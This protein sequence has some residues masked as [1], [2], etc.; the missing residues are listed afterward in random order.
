MKSVNTV[1]F[2]LSAVVFPRLLRKTKLYFFSRSLQKCTFCVICSQF[3]AKTLHFSAVMKNTLPEFQNFIVFSAG[4]GHQKIF[5]KP[6]IKKKSTVRWKGAHIPFDTRTCNRCEIC[7]T[8]FA[9][10]VEPRYTKNRE[11]LYYRKI[12]N[13]SP[14]FD[15]EF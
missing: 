5:I 2:F 8:Q 14:F 6:R 10:F 11:I 1:E 15:F 3:W 12:A 13:V 4:R 9:K 7:R